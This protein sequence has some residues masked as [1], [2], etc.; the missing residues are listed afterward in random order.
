MPSS[1]SQPP[2]FA[3][4][5]T[6]T[7]EDAEKVLG[8]NHVNRNIREG[9]LR[10]Y[11]RDMREGRWGAKTGRWKGICTTPI[12]LDDKDNLLDGQH[13]LMAQVYANVTMKWYVIRQADADIQRVI[14]IG[15][16]RSL[17]DELKFRGYH[18][19]SQVG[20]VARMCLL[21]D[22]GRLS[23]ASAD[24]LVSNVEVIEFLEKHP[25]IEHSANMGKTATN[26]TMLRMQPAPLGAAHWWITQHVGMDEA[27]HFV[28]R[29]STLAGEP[30]R[31]AVLALVRR[32]N[33][34]TNPLRGDRRERIEPRWA[35]YA[36]IKAWN[37]AAKGIRV[38]RINL[39]T[40]DGAYRILIPVSPEDASD[41][42]LE[43]GDT[44][45]E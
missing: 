31:S 40:R 17:A 5:E 25:E 10:S 18:Q 8:K 11:T 24:R 36:V 41:I 39:K 29:L 34:A 13:R 37:Y 20:A 9:K 2:E 30:E 7:V 21:L 15:S 45:D 26:K 3:P 16:S 14:D 1:K 43:K 38:D 33:E 19:T 6:W 32:M 4:L 42:T 28:H 27:D 23:Q 12:V 44:G 22:T 35:L